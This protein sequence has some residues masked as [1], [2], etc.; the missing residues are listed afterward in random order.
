ALWRVAAAPEEAA[1]AYA[2]AIALLPAQHRLY[3]ERD[4]LLAARGDT[5]RRIALLEASPRPVRERSEVAQ[6]LASAYVAAG[7][8]EDALAILG[9]TSFIAGEGEA[10]V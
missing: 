2:R 9:R 5:A 10:S 7:R 1:A 4:R 6:A 3:V 8:F